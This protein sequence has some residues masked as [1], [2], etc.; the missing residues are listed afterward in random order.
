MLINL[1]GID[2]LFSLGGV[3]LLFAF[4]LSFFFPPIKNKNDQEGIKLA[5]A[6]RERNYEHIYHFGKKEVADTFRL[7]RGKLS[8]SSSLFILAG[9]QVTIGILG[10]IL[11]AFTELELRIRKEDISQ[12]AILP[13]GLGMVIGGVLIGK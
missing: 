9:I 2:Y 5:R 7:I 10:V 3:V 4:V 11:P 1:L 12:I 13:L 6:I 8:V